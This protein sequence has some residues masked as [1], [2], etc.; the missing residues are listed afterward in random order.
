MQSRWKHRRA[1]VVLVWLMLLLAACQP[2]AGD[3]GPLAALMRTPSSTPDVL[4]FMQVPSPAC[5]V[6][7]WASMQTNRPQGDL[8]AWS[9]DGTRLA[10]LAPQPATSWYVG[11]ASVAIGPRFED[12]SELVPNLMAVGDLTWS[13]D[14]TQIAF[15]ALR[16]DENVQ[17][18][19]V[20]RMN[21]GS[22][23]DLFP[24]DQ[25]RGDSRT[26]QKSIIGWRDNNRI[27]VFSSCGED[28]QQEYEIHVITGAARPAG[29]AQRRNASI[30]PTPGVVKVLDSLEPEVNQ[31]SYDPS[32]FPRVFNR[33]NWSPDGT[34]VLYLDRRGLLWNLNPEAKTQYVIEIG[35][36]DVDETKWSPDGL[37]AAIRAED[38]IYVFELPCGG[39]AL[40]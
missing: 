8:L 17:T 16:G 9:P 27:R 31:R 34:Q 33:P 19:L 2:P 25:A 7:D 37:R 18:V 24:F 10:Y 3:E 13:P 12:R 6:A 38:R 28:C 39:R 5:L 29:G 15:V 30:T 20:S 11:L 26:S 4:G 40:P 35:L 1:A 36:R 22:L 14:G 32:I 21:D 23:T